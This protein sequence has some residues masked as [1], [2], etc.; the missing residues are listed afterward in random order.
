MAKWMRCGAC[1]CVMTYGHGLTECSTRALK[2]SGEHA[3]EKLEMCTGCPDGEH[4]AKWCPESKIAAVTKE[5]AEAKR[6]L[7]QREVQLAGC[8]VA[9]LGWNKEPALKGQYGWSP[10]YGDVLA[11]RLKFET[12]VEAMKR[13]REEANRLLDHGQLISSSWVSERLGDALAA[14]RASEEKT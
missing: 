4:H 12:A 7:E 6:D 13:V 8:G 1:G 10:S 2:I 5:L 11:L 9:A 14:I 3:V